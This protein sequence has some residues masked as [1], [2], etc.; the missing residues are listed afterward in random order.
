MKGNN[1]PRC[2]DIHSHL[3]P[4]VDDGAQKIEDTL[5]SV[6]SMNRSGIDKILTTPHLKG[7]LTQNPV[8]IRDRLTNVDEAFEQA[9]K[10]VRQAFPTV[11]FKR[12]HEVMLDVP[13]VDF[14]DPRVRLAGT[15]FVLIEWPLLRV[16]PSTSQVLEGIIRDGYRPIV[17]HP[18]RYSTDRGTD[19]YLELLSEWKAVG[20]YLQVNHGSLVGR[21]G[22]KARSISMH[23][24]QRGWAD[25]LA[26]D[27]HG[28]SGVKIYLRE[29]RDRLEPLCG[30]ESLEH[31][32]CTNPDR[33]FRDELPI[34][35][36]AVNPKVGLWQKAKSL[37]SRKKR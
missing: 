19:Y 9:A 28:Q 37:I 29:A 3:V 31:L 20:A 17:A 5:T 6:G 22:Q 30:S 21:Y 24:I 33:V 1:S 15:S 34:P 27:F 13:D 10:V 35:V 4:G 7:S 14:S 26:S 25:Y 16:P 2:V 11:E 32:F 12:G 18:E 23:I 36:S 8:A